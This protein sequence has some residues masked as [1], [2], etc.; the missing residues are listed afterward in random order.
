MKR[1]V[2]VLGAALFL[3]NVMLA[4]G[5]AAGD[6]C[7]ICTRD[8]GGDC[9]GAGYCDPGGSDTGDNRKKC[10]EKGCKIGGTA[11]CPSGA[12]VKVC[13]ALVVAPELETLRALNSMVFEHLQSRATR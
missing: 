1:F 9:E 5:A 6:T 8:S 10:Q 4:G 7:F 3:V 11:S 2:M 13:K 12:N